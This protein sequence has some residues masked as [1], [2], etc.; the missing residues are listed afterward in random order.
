M[1]MQ[2]NWTID[3]LSLELGISC[4]SVSN[5]LNN[6]G[7]R[8]RGPR[9]VP[10]DLTES[11]KTV[12]VNVALQNLQAFQR[13]ARMLSRIIAF[14]ETVW[15]CYTPL[16]RDQCAEWLRPGERVPTRVAQFREPWSRHLVMA[17]HQNQIIGY[18]WL[19]PG[20]TWNQNTIIRFLNGT[21]REYVERHMI[22]V[23]PIILMDG[24]RW[25]TGARTMRLIREEL[26]WEILP[27]PPF[28]FVLILREYQC[29]ITHIINIYSPDFDPL[30][31]EIF[32]KIKRPYKG[33]RFHNSTELYEAVENIV[34]NLNIDHTLIGT[35][36]LPLVWQRIIDV[37]GEY[38]FDHVSERTSTRNSNSGQ[39]SGC[40]NSYCG[41]RTRSGRIRHDELKK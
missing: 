9:W 1:S 28:R 13:D 31:R 22:G 41:P 19:A 2:R 17:I 37:N 20:E 12:R 32:Q 16:D 5:L 10:H 29:K 3:E 40:T 24:A 15:R 36:H 6:M 14:D 39:F 21:L 30:D 35:T 4:G 23:T 27:H 33:R 11:Q 18:E 25:H 7:F 8:K 34:A 38:F 26:K